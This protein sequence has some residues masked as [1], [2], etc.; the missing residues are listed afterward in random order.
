MISHA[1]PLSHSL[2]IED[3]GENVKTFFQGKLEVDG[4]ELGASDG[5]VDYVHF[6]VYG[7][8]EF[9]NFENSQTVTIIDQ[10][11]FLGKM[12]FES[13]EHEVAL[14]EIPTKEPNG[15][16]HAGV[17]RRIDRSSFSIDELKTVLKDLASMLTFVAGTPRWPALMMAS[18]SPDHSAVWGRMGDLDPLASNPANWFLNMHGGNVQRMFREMSSINRERSGHMYS[19]IEYYS[20]SGMARHQYMET[21]QNALL[22]SYAGL[23]AL[24]Q[25]ILEREKQPDEVDKDYIN[26]ALT[27]AD[28]KIGNSKR[29]S[30]VWRI[31]DMRNNY[32][33]GNLTALAQLEINDYWRT[34]N[35]SQRYIE[36]FILRLCNYQGG[37]YNRVE[38]RI[39]SVPWI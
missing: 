4:H 8:P 29:S 20:A 5:D 14:V 17:L 24:A 28:L 6:S 11:H 23:E 31:A 9:H 30:D 36:L 7:F 1:I 16:T 15:P 33:H 34:W 3:A 27:E 22:V 25:L 35:K 12:V 32:A 37:Y 2:V 38:N 21:V 26:E 18:K 39:E 10:R 13:S 19:V